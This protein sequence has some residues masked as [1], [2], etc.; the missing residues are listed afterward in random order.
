MTRTS[1]NNP[2]LCDGCHGSCCKAAWIDGPVDHLFPEYVAEC[3][4]VRGREGP[5]PKLG[6]DGRCTIYA[7]RPFACK[8][9]EAGSEACLRA[10][11]KFGI[12]PPLEEK[13]DAEDA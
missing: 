8:I 3:L 4:A 2:R 13:E 9:Y 12:D 7:T 11:R 10:R 1:L 6:L 5:C